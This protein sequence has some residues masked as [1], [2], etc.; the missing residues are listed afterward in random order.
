MAFSGLSWADMGSDSEY[1]DSEQSEA[2]TIVPESEKVVVTTP[3]GSDEDEEDE[4]RF[5][6]ALLNNVKGASKTSTKQKAPNKS[7]DKSNE[8]V[9]VASSSD[10]I[11][12]DDD[13]FTEVKRKSRKARQRGLCFAGKPHD[14]N[15]ERNSRDA[16]RRK[17]AA[18]FDR[19]LAKKSSKVK[20]VNGKVNGFIIQYN[21]PNPDYTRRGKCHFLYLDESD[22]HVR[23]FLRWG[24][25]KTPKLFGN[26]QGTCH[27]VC[28]NDKKAPNC[29]DTFM[30]YHHMPDEVNPDTETFDHFGALML[31]VNNR[32]SEQK[33]IDAVTEITE[34]LVNVRNMEEK[35]ATG[36]SDEVDAPSAD[37]QLND[38]EEVLETEAELAVN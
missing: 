8:L 27:R 33:Y 18:A 36:Q 13:G 23:N 22:E 37:I 38:L 11:V 7:Q 10:Q 26:K 31:I 4:F 28:Y 24:I 20:Y 2:E 21:Q 19:Q 12:D 30:F 29:I 32:I 3:Q 35:K 1:S 34:F 9:G 16:E 6:I 5:A 25:E 15:A 14:P 17:N